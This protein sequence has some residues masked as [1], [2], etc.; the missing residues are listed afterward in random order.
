MGSGKTTFTR[1]LVEALKIN[2]RVQSPTF[3]IVR[4]YKGNDLVINHVDL[5]RLTSLREVKD[6]GLQ[7]LINEENA[8]T[9]I[10]WPGKAEKILPEHTKKMEFE[11]IDETVRKVKCSNF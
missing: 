5:Y 10:E 2:S 6:I 1:Y 8:I 3:V 7:E 4:K 11:F 9:I